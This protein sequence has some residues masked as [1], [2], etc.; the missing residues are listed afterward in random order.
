MGKIN[1]VLAVWGQMLREVHSQSV[2]AE[3]YRSYQY[4]K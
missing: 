4:T 3:Q 2:R 1:G